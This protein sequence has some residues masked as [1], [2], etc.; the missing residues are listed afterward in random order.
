MREG[1]GHDKRALDFCDVH[2]YKKGGFELVF[3]LIIT[4]KKVLLTNYLNNLTF[5]WEPI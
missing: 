1:A 2:T 5:N 4:L 3:F